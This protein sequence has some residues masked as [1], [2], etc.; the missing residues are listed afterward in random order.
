M[1]VEKKPEEGI[2]YMEVAY[3]H[4]NCNCTRNV[5]GGGNCTSGVL[6]VV[7]VA[8]TVTVTLVVILIPTEVVGTEDTAME[9]AM[10]SGGPCTAV[11]IP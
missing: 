6:A 3:A 5:Y 11:P 9:V 7:L 8:A 2:V 4:S 1:V 10:G